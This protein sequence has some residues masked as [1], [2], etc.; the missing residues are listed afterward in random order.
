MGHMIL[1]G[2]ASSLSPTIIGLM[3]VGV[4][5]GIVFG[6]TPGLTGA[7]AMTLLLPVSYGMDVLPAVLLLIAIWNAAVWAGAVPAIVMNIPGTSAAA[8]TLLDGHP[9][10][11]KGLATRALRSSIIGAFVGSIAAA[12]ALLFVAPALGYVVSYLGPAE[13][14]AFATFGLTL[15]VSVT[16]GSVVNAIISALIG[17]L[18]GT[19]GF[20]PSGFP[21]FVF[22][23]DL[24][25]G[26]PLIP[27]LI[28]LFTFP[29]LMNLIRERRQRI[30]TAELVKHD[31]F[32]LRAGD[33]AAHWFNF[34][35]SAVVGVFM[36]MHPGAGPSISSFVTY[37]EA[38][39]VSKTKP[40]FGEGNVDGVIAAD[41]GA[42]AAVLSGLIPAFTL[43]IPGSV[44]TIIIIAALTLHGVE[45]GPTL[46]EKHGQLAYTIFAGAFIANVLMLIIGLLTA[47]WIANV[48]RVP[49][50]V[51]VPVV[52]VL[53]LVGAYSVDNTWFDVATALGAGLLGYALR[54]MRIS[55]I[56]LLLGLILG[57][58]L[59]T[60]LYQAIQVYGSLPGA[61][62]T[63]PVALIFLLISVANLVHA[64]I[65]RRGHRVAT[66][67]V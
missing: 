65:A 66:D 20:A 30:V 60:N 26:F 7:A 41:T 62:F 57:P 28:G 43:G 19:F 59:E 17:L 35:R 12:L 64:S 27:A 50:T 18:I 52:T 2:F 38:R 21:R 45:P 25:S 47:R 33:W 37:N 48:A 58:I 36:G 40:E 34:V 31:T 46:F 39:R 13:V 56:P 22:T 29:E 55:T 32:L 6:S 11:R 51:L 24:L 5:I 1:Q 8:A 54:S 9:M 49:S 10:A 67:A 4:V 63:R 14:F 53:A 16:R 15:V 61:I 3:A 44:D 42:N 23:P